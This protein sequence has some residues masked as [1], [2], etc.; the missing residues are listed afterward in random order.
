MEFKERSLQGIQGNK[1][2]S[3]EPPISSNNK[4]GKELDLILRGKNSA[5]QVNAAHQSVGGI[6]IMQLSKVLMG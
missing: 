6:T 2:S 5:P 3:S 4:F 1:N